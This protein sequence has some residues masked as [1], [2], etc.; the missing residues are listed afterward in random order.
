MV[1]A[2]G[3]LFIAIPLSGVSQQEMTSP[4]SRRRPPVRE[5]ELGL[6][7]WDYGSI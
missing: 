7:A 3:I 1:P 5:P 4:C 2:V 6:N